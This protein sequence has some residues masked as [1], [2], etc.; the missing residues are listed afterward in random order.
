MTL[1]NPTYSQAGTVFGG[2]AALQTAG[3]AIRGAFAYLLRRYREERAI[4]H[5]MEM[6]VRELK[7]LG[8]SRGQ[9]ETV[10]RRG[11]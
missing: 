8:I 1:M 5:L 7:D 6:D 9:I 3:R 2:R 10:V 4:E 11:R